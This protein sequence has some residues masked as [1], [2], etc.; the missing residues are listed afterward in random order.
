MKL[1]LS[2]IPASV[3]V[4]IKIFVFKNLSRCSKNLIGA[5]GRISRF[6]LISRVV[7]SS[8]NSEEVAASRS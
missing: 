4:V 2:I 5:V 3:G 6:S 1:N 7:T 8:S